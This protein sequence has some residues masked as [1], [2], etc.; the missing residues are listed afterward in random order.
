MKQQASGSP[1]D[2]H[3]EVIAL[4][5]ELLTRIT[6]GRSNTALLLIRLLPETEL[7]SSVGFSPAEVEPRIDR[8]LVQRSSAVQEKVK[9]KKREKK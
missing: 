6:G 5:G 4:I 8:Q 7:A 2:L 9:K 3:P 1:G